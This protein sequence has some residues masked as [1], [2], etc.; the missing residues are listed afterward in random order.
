MDDDHK[1]LIRL[2]QQNI[3]ESRQMAENAI[4]SSVRY[5]AFCVA[6][7]AR[8]ADDRAY[9]ERLKASQSQTGIIRG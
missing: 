3:A 2:A 5:N 4:A 7:R 1:E 9:I 6:A 8:L